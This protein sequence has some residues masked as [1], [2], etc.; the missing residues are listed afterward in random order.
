M[1]WRHP[2][3]D[4]Q[5]DDAAFGERLVERRVVE[6]V[7]RCPGAAMNLDQRWK[8]AASLRLVEPRE[9]WAV[10]RAPIFEVPRF[11]LVGSGNGD[12]VRHGILLSGTKCTSKPAMPSA[13]ALVMVCQ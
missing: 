11:D 7:A 9:K 12:I 10:F 4:R 5:H 8:W 2:K 13:A 6:P 3:I 1:L